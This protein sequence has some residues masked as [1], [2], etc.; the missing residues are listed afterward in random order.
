MRTVKLSKDWLL[1]TETDNEKDAINSR[2][3]EMEMYGT[4]RI[5][6][7]Q[8]PKIPSFV[9]DRSWGEKW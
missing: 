1:T 4:K 8:F 6:L 3:D 7:L 5:N 2:T 9:P